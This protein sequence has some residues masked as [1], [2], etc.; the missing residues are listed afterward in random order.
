MSARARILALVAVAT[1]AAAGIAVAAGLRGSGSEQAAT[2]PAARLEG[3][4]PLALDLGLGD[5]ARTR[6]LR[7]AGR[8]YSAGRL[9][10]AAA[11]FERYGTLPARIGGAFAAWP[12]GTVERLRALVASSP[13]SGQARLHLGLALYW[14]RRLDQ[15][16]AAWRAAVRAEPDSPAAI[17][18]YDLLHP[19]SPRGLPTFVPSFGPPPGL[20]GMAPARQLAVLARRAREGGVRDRLLYGVALQRAGRPVSAER[21]YAS[22]ARLAPRDVEA[23]V[24]AAVGRFRKDRP[25]RAFS[26][27]GPLARRYP[28]SPTVRFHLGLLLIWL[29]ELEDGRRQLALARDA[30]PRSPLGKE[31]NRFL[32]RLEGDGSG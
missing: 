13:R 3:P 23:Q 8:L 31:A 22:A 27:L 14:S 21:A 16:A 15:A 1:V 6:A 5:D 9:A 32:S 2:P 11:I 29:G 12:V 18:A 17:R 30:G 19:D 24:A 10:E 26:R 4:P 28:R 7:R 25:A 20:A